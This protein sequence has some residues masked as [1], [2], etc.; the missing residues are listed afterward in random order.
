M[1]GKGGRAELKR[2]ACFAHTA[3]TTLGGSCE[4]PLQPHHIAKSYSQCIKI[5]RN[6]L[7]QLAD[8]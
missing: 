6:L 5:V 1:T 8:K 4:R 3:V 7:L 2:R